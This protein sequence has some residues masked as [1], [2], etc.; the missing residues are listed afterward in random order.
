ME[1]ET[2]FQRLFS[3][4]IRHRYYR[5]GVSRDFEIEPTSLTRRLMGNYGLLFR[6]TAAGFSLL[7]EA[8]PTDSTHQKLRKS[9]EENLRF[10]F[11]LQGRD[12]RLLNYSDLPL[13]LPAGSV[14]SL[15]NLKDNVEN[16]R[17]LLTR[18]SFLSSEDALPAKPLMFQYRHPLTGSGP[19][20]RI[21]D[22]T[23]ATVKRE[24]LTAGEGD[25]LWA[26]DLRAHGP[27]QYRLDVDGTEQARFY[28]SNEPAGQGI[29]AMI[30]ILHGSHVPAAYRFADPGQDPTVKP[31]TYI[32]EIDTRRTH[33][34]YTVVLKYRLKDKKPEEWPP[35]WPE[36]WAVLVP[37]DP[38]VKIQPR[39]GEIKTVADGNLAVPF[40]AD[41]PL[42]LQDEPVKGIA[43]KKVNGNGN[44][45]GLRELQNLPNPSLDGIVPVPEENKVF[46]E[47]FVYI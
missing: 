14:Y 40:V 16:G 3:V 20:L 27:G 18:S 44:G 23:G 37:G 4:D 26:V 39:P 25:A 19:E 31:K 36:D 21:L 29:F 15:N 34:K 8:D 45:S 10:S 42:P 12:H 6:K 24:R 43:L 1:M 17:L 38:T 28:A 9:L 22:E 41:T 5:D 33:W 47:V 32:M 7:Y 46:S 2:V 13:D 35:G 11:L 30:D